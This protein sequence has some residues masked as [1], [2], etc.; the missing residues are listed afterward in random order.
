MTDK[1]RGKGGGKTEDVG[2]MKDKEVN[3]QETE[4]SH[5]LGGLSNTLQYINL[6]NFAI[7]LVVLRGPMSR[8]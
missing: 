3:L 5:T 2:V 7:G 8:F 4:G 6:A 1:T